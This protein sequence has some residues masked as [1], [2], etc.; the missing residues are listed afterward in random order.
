M[1]ST[2][3]ESVLL[4]LGRSPKK[5]TKVVAYPTEKF[6]E[7]R[8]ACNKTYIFTEY[9]DRRKTSD[10]EFDVISYNAYPSALYK[11]FHPIQTSNGWAWKSDVVKVRIDTTWFYLLAAPLKCGPACFVEHVVL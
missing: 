4:L 3:L 6:V 7:V 2:Q 9:W 8:H 10:S 11:I 5:V 1:K